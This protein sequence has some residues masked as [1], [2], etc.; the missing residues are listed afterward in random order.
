MLLMKSTTLLLQGG[1]IAISPLVLPKRDPHTIVEVCPLLKVGTRSFFWYFLWCFCKTWICLEVFPISKEDSLVHKTNC[2]S[3]A[4][5][6]SWALANWRR[7][8][9]WRSL[10][11]GF[12]AATQ[13]LKPRLWAQQPVVVT[14]IG[15]S[16]RSLTL[17]IFI[18]G[19]ALRRLP[20]WRRSCLLVFQGL[21]GIGAVSTVCCSENQATIPETVC[22]TISNLRVIAPFVIPALERPTIRALSPV[23]GFFFL[24]VGILEA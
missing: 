12:L 21:P 13:L 14:D 11:K 22:R 17:A 8:A 9:L 20:N 23:E 7:L 4:V 6:C 10:R 15:V 5:Q 19:F 18:Q 16:I 1:T 24:H 2:Q 3:L